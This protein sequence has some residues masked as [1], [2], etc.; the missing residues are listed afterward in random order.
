MG[1]WRSQGVW[2]GAIK[3]VMVLLMSLQRL[4]TF[5]EVYRQRSIS[6][7]ARSLDLTQP[8]VS[9][10][11]AGLEEAVGHRLFERH[12]QGVVPTATAD[13]LAADIGDKLDAAEAALASARARSADM[14]GAIQIIGHADFLAEVVAPGLQSLLEA[15]MRVRL[16]T[17]DCDLV[18]KMLADGQCDLGISYDPITD[19]RLRSEPIRTERMLAVAHPS[20]VERLLRAPDLG[21]A[22]AVE[23][24]LAYSLE[25]PLIDDWLARNGFAPHQTP[26]AMIGQD[27][28]SLCTLLGQGFGWAVLPEYVCAPRL[29]REELRE[30][31]AP[32]GSM[33]NTYFL[34]W[35]PSALRHPRIA[36]ARQTLIWHLRG[37]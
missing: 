21:Q 3:F 18:Q 20:V 12:V 35:T 14:A 1:R 26:P 30:I 5:I 16:Q 8:A 4:R 28:R 34:A 13:E 25:R 27:L 17:G 10:H 29:H 24:A 33:T 7:A 22:L 32:L 36:H 23:P 6:A 15:G 2:R 11:I 9:Q 37:K 19:R 31:P